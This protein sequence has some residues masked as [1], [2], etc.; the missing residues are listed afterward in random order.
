MLPLRDNIPLARFPAVTVALVAINL[1]AYLVEILHGGS[2]LG[3]PSR[4]VAVRYGAIPYELA[5]P[6]RHC[7]LVAHATGGSVA[8]L[9]ACEGRPG[10]PAAAAAQPASGATVIT[11]L[12]LGGGFLQVLANMLAL[13]IFGP[14]VEDTLGRVR[15]A[16]L[17]LLGGLL[18]LGL[19]V[20]A[21]PSS[22]APV[23]GASGSVAAVLGGYLLLN[24]RARVVTLVFAIFF[25]T[26]V[27]APALLLLGLWSLAQ[28]YVVAAGL[29]GPLTGHT[30]GACLAVI[31][32]FLFGMLAIAVLRARR[33]PDPSLPVY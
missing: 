13:A 25:V 14:T 27:E 1:I 29:A 19:Q 18:A 33:P 5:H 11:S 10:G 21:D 8:S 23:L 9:L 4:S 30:A 2:L 12:F 7:Q 32:A 20:L 22:V 26:I 28:A 24:P 17:Y 6:G 16:L 31:G 15:F 3:G